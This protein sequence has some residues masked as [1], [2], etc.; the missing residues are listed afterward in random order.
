MKHNLFYEVFMPDAG[1]IPLDARDLFQSLKSGERFFDFFASNIRNK[2]T[3][4]ACFVAARNFS[5]WFKERGI[6]DQAKVK[7]I[8]QAY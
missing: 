7:P 5:R 2:N 3:R 1:I 6:S 8:R 4:S